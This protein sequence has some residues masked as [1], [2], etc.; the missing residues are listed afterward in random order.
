MPE[1]LINE[2]LDP[3]LARKLDA[4]TVPALPPGFADRLVAAALAV[5]D[6]PLAGLPP[7]RRSPARRWLRGGAAGLGAIAVGMISISAAA[8]GYFGEPIRNA[9]SQAP[10]IGSVIERVIPKAARQPKKSAPVRLAKPAAPRIEVPAAV[11]VPVAGP[12]ARLTP[13]ERR[14]RVREILADPEKRRAWIAAHPVAAE[15]IARRAELRRRRL[16][17]G[18]VPPA[19]AEASEPLQGPVRPLLR[20]GRAERLER[21]ER[22]RERRRLRLERRG[23]LR[24]GGEGLPQVEAEPS[25]DP[26]P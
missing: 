8:M 9:V 12:P 11:P 25:V 19:R 23:L 21:L 1:P 16:E 22:L 20:P 18:L 13:I 26:V 6:A 7:L 10:V 24:E 4:F 15:R 2:P 14:Q 5:P 17:A 3:A